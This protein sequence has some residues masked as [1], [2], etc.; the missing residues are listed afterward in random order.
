VRYAGQPD[1]APFIEILPELANGAPGAEERFLAKWN[2]FLA[3][4]GF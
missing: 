4:N 1:M 3:T 2:A